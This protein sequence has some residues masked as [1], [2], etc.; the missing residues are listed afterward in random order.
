MPR[1]GVIT[2]INAFFSVTQGVALLGT[3]A[4]FTAQL[5]I[6]ELPDNTFTAV[7]GAVVTL[8]PSFTGVISLGSRCSGITTGLAIPVAAQD[9]LLLVFSATAAGL[10][11]INTFEGYASAGLDI[12]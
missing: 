6:S 3:T 11:L 7:P 4:S 8:S 2:G 5:Y 9:R 1:D 12:E 10:S